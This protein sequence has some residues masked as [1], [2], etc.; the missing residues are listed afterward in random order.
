M[1][2]RLSNSVLV[3]YQHLHSVWYRK[4]QLYLLPLSLPAEQRAFA[5]DECNQAMI[6]LF[7]TIDCAW[8]NHPFTIEP[9]RNK[10]YQLRIA[11]VI[12]FNVPRT[13]VT[14]D[15]ALVR[16][17][18]D[19]LRG[20]IVYKSLS[21]PF[22]VG[23]K[24]GLDHGFIKASIYTTP[25]EPR[26]L[27][28]LDALKTAPGIFQEYVSKRVE[29]RVTVVGSQLFAAEIHS[30]DNPGTRHDWRRE[31]QG[32]A[33]CEPHGL[34]DS[35]ATLCLRLMKEL[36]L[37]FG[38]IDMILTPDNRYVFL[39]INPNGQYGWIERATGLRISEAL[40]KHL[41]K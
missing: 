4:P 37:E 13:L 26:H 25:L 2:L 24:T 23:T 12:G 28:F 34:P 7:N 21:R 10:P 30:Q 11:Q 36:K 16:H 35:V 5:I 32:A 40:A 31:Q 14:N 18:Y 9:A 20:Q 8:T 15:P 33:V 1:Q 41:A 17:F 6:A 38:A 29:L 27:D 19:D 3:E 39:E 22:F